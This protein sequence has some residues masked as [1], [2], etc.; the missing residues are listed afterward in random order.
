MCFDFGFGPSVGFA[1]QETRRFTKQMLLPA[2]FS[3]KWQNS[4]Y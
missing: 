2:P 3:K 4:T 1:L